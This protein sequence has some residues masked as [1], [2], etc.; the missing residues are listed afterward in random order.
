M[1]GKIV[2]DTLEHSTAGSIATN[3]VVDGSLKAWGNVEQTGTQ[4]LNASLNVS[5][6]ADGGVGL[7]AY[8][9]GTSFS[10]SAYSATAACENFNNFAGINT[11]KSAN[12]I[13]VATANYDA[14]LEDR[15]QN[16]MC[17]GDLA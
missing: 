5:S 14:T 7:T 16:V 15:N 6:I 9:F 12:S 4:S 17:A 10:T 8:N 1:A 13:T 3:Y 11:G 2:A